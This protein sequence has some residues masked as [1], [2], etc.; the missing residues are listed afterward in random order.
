MYTKYKNHTIA[1][2]AKDYDKDDEIAIVGGG[3]SGLAS[4]YFLTEA[5]HN[6]E[7]ITIYEKRNYV[8]G[9]ARTVYLHKVSDTEMYAIQDYDIEFENNYQDFFLCYTDHKDSEQRVKINDNPVVI[10][11]DIGVCG[12]SVNYINFKHLLSQLTTQENIPFFQYDYLEDVNRA[13][14]LDG[15]FVLRSDKFLFGQ[16]WRPWNWLRLFRLRSDVEK[17]MEYFAAKDLSHWQATPIQTLLDDLRAQGISQ[18][19]LDLLVA[20]CQVGSGYKNSLFS[21]I[22]AGYLYTFFTI[23]NFNNAGEHNTTFLHG[24][25]VYMLKFATY[26]KSL[27]IKIEKNWEDTAKHTIFAMQPY[28][29]RKINENLPEIDSS[30]SLLYIHCDQSILG[31]MDTVLSYGKIKGIAQATWDLDRMRPEHPDVGAY[32][33]FT[34]PDFEET[35]DKTL[36]KGQEAIELKPDLKN[37]HNLYKAPIKNIWRHAIIDVPAEMAR[38]DIWQNYQG[39]DN[40]YYCSSSYLYCMLHE[41]AVT[42]ALDT[43]CMITGQDAKLKGQ[44]FKPSDYTY[45]I[46]G[47]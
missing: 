37:G 20:F 24:V 38:R 32:I 36:F 26:L 11:V 21:E 2:L 34:I 19:A 30:E 27:G 1:Q 14:S 16:L 29:A 31:G 42:S 40:R 7:K 25:S 9:H 35:L 6:P 13:I 5:G 17:I 18:D 10:P 12:F 43:V 28:E 45:D 3:A 15:N 22:T 23:G 44:G 47:N 4:A 8:G 41:N 46:H 39:Q 33:T